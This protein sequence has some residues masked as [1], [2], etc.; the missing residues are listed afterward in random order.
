MLTAFAAAPRAPLAEVSTLTAHDRALVLRAGR[1]PRPA[2]PAGGT[3]PELFATRAAEGPERVA[4]CSGG[5]ILTYA[6]LDARSTA[7][8]HALLEAGVRPG[9]RVGVCLAPSVRL[10][11][12]LLAVLKTGA[13]YVPLDP[14]Y[15]RA[16]LAFL[17]EDTGIALAVTD[18]G[19]LDGLAGL[20]TLPPDASPGAAGPLPAVDPD[21]VAYVIHTSGSTGRPKGVLVPHRNVAALLA[22]TAGPVPAVA[23]ARPAATGATGATGGTGVRQVRAGSASARGRVVVLPLLRVRLLGVG[24]VGAC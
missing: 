14:E 4:V 19:A 16:R 15:P 6:A 21:A 2:A 20:R 7:L 18:T 22:A 17:A 23:T 1:G 10:V 8:A 5:D 12:A 11:V 9:E 24:G 13:A 3:I